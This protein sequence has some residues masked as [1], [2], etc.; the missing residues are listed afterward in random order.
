MQYFVETLNINEI[1]FF[2]HEYS[3]S[4]NDFIQFLKISLGVDGND[5][6]FLRLWTWEFAVSLSLSRNDVVKYW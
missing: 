6:Y 4:K 1:E 5:R 2:Q 3:I